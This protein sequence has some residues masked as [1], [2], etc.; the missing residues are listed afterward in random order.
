MGDGNLIE[1]INTEDL[2][3]CANTVRGLAMDAVQRANSIEYG[4]RH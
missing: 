4:Y 3:K 1:S 2:T